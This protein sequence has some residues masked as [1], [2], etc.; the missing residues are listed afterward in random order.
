MI[1]GGYILQP[2]IIDQSEAMNFN[3]TT[4]E[5][6][7]FLLR[8]ANHKD[9]GKFKRGQ[10]FLSL[11]DMQNGLSWYSG[12]RKNTYSKP[13]LTKALRRLIESNMIETTKEI[14]GL[15]ITICEYDYYQ[16]PKNYEG[17]DKET[18]KEVDRLKGGRAINKN[19]KNTI[20]KDIVISDSDL[21]SIYGEKLIS[22]FQDH[23]NEKTKSGKCRW[24]L[25]KVFEIKK[26]LA[27]WKKNQDTNFGRNPIIKK[28]QTK[29]QLEVKATSVEEM[30]PEANR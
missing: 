18:P 22:E 4:R 23:W 28:V 30:F 15:T 12:Y 6:W 29:N 11:N 19:E 3:P 7:L 8:R 21:I 1:K 13:Q 20:S 25:Q 16:D 10:C 24:E 9:N 2:R 27:T 17:N 14:R 5:L 26:R